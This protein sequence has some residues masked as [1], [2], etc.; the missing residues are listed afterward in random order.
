MF[1]FRI[2]THHVGNKPL[3]SA[4][5][6][7]QANTQT[8]NGTSTPQFDRHAVLV[9]C[10][11]PVGHGVGVS[12]GSIY[13][14]Q[15]LHTLPRRCVFLWLLLFLL[16]LFCVRM[17]FLKCVVHLAFVDL[18]GLMTTRLLLIR[19]PPCDGRSGFSK[20]PPCCHQLPQ[21][22]RVVDLRLLSLLPFLPSGPLLAR[23]SLI[24][25]HAC[26]FRFLCCVSTILRWYG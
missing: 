8:P 20:L 22:Q 26:L 15:C 3:K 2:V 7:E 23:W 4:S 24:S 18:A 16:L 12:H 19:H 21:Q 14:Q 25:F 10:G 9:A 6:A 1:L 11:V 5:A 17:A 13:T